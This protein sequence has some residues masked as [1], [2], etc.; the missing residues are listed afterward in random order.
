MTAAKICHSFC[1]TPREG[2]AGMEREESGMFL[3]MQHRPSQCWQW[4]QHLGVLTCAFLK[5]PAPVSKAACDNISAMPNTKASSLFTDAKIARSRPESTG[6]FDGGSSAVPGC[7]V[8][9]SK[10]SCIQ[11]VSCTEFH[12]SF[13]IL[14]VND[15]SLEAPIAS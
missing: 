10:R 14:L 1:E 5:N 7:A 6:L 11:R 8:M 15:R 2:T 12:I 4:P 13:P 3:D 9:P